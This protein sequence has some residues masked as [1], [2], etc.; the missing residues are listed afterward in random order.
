MKYEAVI[1]DLDGTLVSTDF[2]HRRI[3]IDKVFSDLK[4]DKCE[5]DLVNQFWFDVNRNELIQKNFNIKPEIF[6]KT[7]KKY[8][9]AELRSKFTKT[10]D[11][12]F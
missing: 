9:S 8:D 6:W 11:W 5:D 12:I 4:V 3:L 7:Y 1:F 2:Q 10:F